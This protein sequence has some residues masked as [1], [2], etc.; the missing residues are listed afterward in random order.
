MRRI[1]NSFRDDLEA[2]QS[3]EVIVIMAKIYSEELSESIYVN[4]DIV[5]YIYND[6]HYIG[7]AFRMSLISD[8]EQP[9][10]AKISVPNVDRRIGSLFLGLSKPLRLKIEIVLRSAFNDESPRRPIGLPAAEY[11]APELY[12]RN[13]SCDAMMVSADI[14]S[15]DLSS[16]PYPRIRSTPDLLPALFR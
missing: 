12:L 9:P 4:S 16:E 15:F 7:L 5:D 2:L 14:A 8:D 3:D 6:F 10:R 13:V 1:S 11:T